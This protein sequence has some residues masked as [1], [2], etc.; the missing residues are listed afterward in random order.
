MTMK[1]N[2]KKPSAAAAA[3][4]AR[5]KS[6]FWLNVGYVVEVDTD[7]GVVERFVSLPFGIPLDTMKPLEISGS[8]DAFA[9]LRMAQNDLLE[10]LLEAANELKPGESRVLGAGDQLAIEI[11]RIKGERTDLKPG[12]NPFARKLQ[13]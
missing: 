3:T 7:E 10:S 13:F 8:S 6:E 2:L 4:E 1:L 5:T 11:R 9:Y 12:A